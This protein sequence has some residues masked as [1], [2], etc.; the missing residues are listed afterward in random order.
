M[1]TCEEFGKEWRFLEYMD[2]IDFRSSLPLRTFATHLALNKCTMTTE[3]KYVYI[4]RNPWDVCVSFFHMVTN[5]SIYEYRNGTFEDFVDTFVSD[6]F[7]YGDYFEHVAAGYAL[8]EEPNVFFV[9]YEELKRNT[10]EVVLRLAFF[11]GDH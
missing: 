5:M 4:A 10:R 7:G 3:G 2:S 9:T 1:T 8:R 11:L 6:N